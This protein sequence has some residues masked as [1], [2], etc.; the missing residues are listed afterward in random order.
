MTTPPDSTFNLPA[1]DPVSII[2]CGYIGKR[3]AQQLRQQGISVHATVSSDDSL[4]ECRKLGIDCEVLDLDES[5]TTMDVSG[6]H[7]IYLAPPPRSGRSDTRM[8]NFLNAMQSSPPARFVLI[9]TTGVYGDCKGAWIDETRPLNPLA[10]RAYRR[11][12]AEAQVRTFCEHHNIPLVILRVAGIYGPGK[13][14][15]KRIQ[16]GEPIVRHED[17]PFTNRI[18]AHDLVDICQQALLD[19]GI[20]GIYNV[21]DGHPGSMYEYFTGIAE[22][23]GLPAPP[24][25]SLE[26]ARTRLSEGMLSYMAE[27]RRIDNTKLLRDF[28]IELQYPTLRDG[29]A[30]IE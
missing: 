11:A 23:L 17:S 20:A 5:Q 3:L 27:S 12:D 7:I 15:V 10:D 1:T 26:Q 13:I 19:K 22:K 8:A 16:S 6:R 14:P 30:M 28:A 18:H 4:A 29:L 24:A 21:T 25:I 2:G 9:S